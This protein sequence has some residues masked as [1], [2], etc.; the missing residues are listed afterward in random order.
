MF[1]SRVQVD[2]KVKDAW[3]IP[4][5]RISGRHHPNDLLGTE[6][7]AGKA[8]AWLKEAGATTTIRFHWTFLDIPSGGQH[9]AGT[10]R[11]VTIRRHPLW[12]NTAGC[13]TWTT[14]TSSMAG[15]CDEWRV[16]PRAYDYGDRLS[17]VENL[18][19]TWKGT[20]GRA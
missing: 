2:G 3:G 20:H 12:T 10:C 15:A 16:Q 9:Q 8:E 13:M 14:C 5:A 7:M 17:R 18:V 6:F 1:E 11:M 4:V 19:K